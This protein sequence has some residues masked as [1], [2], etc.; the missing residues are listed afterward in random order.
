MPAVPR[1][2]AL[3]LIAATGVLPAVAEESLS[4]VDQVLT[5]VKASSC[6]YETN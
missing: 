4:G 6:I 1:F 3:T 5:E 2:V